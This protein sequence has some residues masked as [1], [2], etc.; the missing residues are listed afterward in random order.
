MSY[1][2]VRHVLTRVQ[3][4]KG[5]WKRK[6]DCRFI[7]KKRKYNS[8]LI[9]E[10]SM[11]EVTWCG[12]KTSRRRIE[13]K[14]HTMNNSKIIKKCTPKTGYNKCFYERERIILFLLKIELHN[15]K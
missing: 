11:V 15:V 6:D 12:K 7:L 10:T 1:V 8:K 3:K 2:S 5:K 14:C 9:M 4:E 13:D